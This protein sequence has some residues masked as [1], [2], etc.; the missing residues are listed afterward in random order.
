MLGARRSKKA[1]IMRSRNLPAARERNGA[2]R[3]V[4]VT[5]LGAVDPGRVQRRPTDR[6]C[7]RGTVP[8]HNYLPRDRRAYRLPGMARACSSRDGVGTICLPE[9]MAVPCPGSHSLKRAAGRDSPPH[10]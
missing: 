7:P 6:P 5:T 10:R 3:L 4:R 9:V 8:V 2:C 1:L